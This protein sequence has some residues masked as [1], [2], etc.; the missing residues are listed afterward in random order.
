MAEN[1]LTVGSIAH[2]LGRLDLKLELENKKI[3]TFEGDA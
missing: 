1:T 2:Q 3:H